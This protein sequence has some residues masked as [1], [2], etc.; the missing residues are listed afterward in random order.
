MCT[1]PSIV[2]WWP[3]THSH[4]HSLTGRHSTRTV[5]HLAHSV[6]HR[7]SHPYTQSRTHRAY[8]I[9]V[10]PHLPLHTHLHKAGFQMMSGDGFSEPHGWDNPSQLLDVNPFPGSSRSLLPTSSTF[11]PLPWPSAH[12]PSPLPFP[13][14]RF[15]AEA[16]VRGMTE[17]G[18]DTL[19]RTVSYDAT[20]GNH[21]AHTFLCISI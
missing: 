14:C 19:S 13:D 1:L 5:T 7:V 15:Q 17:S 11:Y 4:R 20:M 21:C 8:L 3:H 10:L 16:D 12:L 18:E 2:S 9:Q 6:T